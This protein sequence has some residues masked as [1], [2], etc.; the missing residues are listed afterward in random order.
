[1]MSGAPVPGQPRRPGLRHPARIVALVLSGLLA[2]PIVVTMWYALRTPTGIGLG[3]FG[4][5]LTDGSVW[6]AVGHSALWALAALLLVLLGLVIALLAQRVRRVWRSLLLVLVVPLGMSSLVAG[7][8]FRLIFDQAPQRGTVNALLAAVGGGQPAWL[9]SNLVWVVLISAFA[10]SWLGFVVSLFRA[11][12]DAIPV[13]IARVAKVEGASPYRRLRAIVLPMLRPVFA[14]VL[15][16]MVV[17]AIR[18]FDLL[19]MVVPDPAQAGTDVLATRWQHLRTSSSDTGRPAALAV[20]LFALLIMVALGCIRGLRHRSAPYGGEPADEPRDD[21]VATRPWPRRGLWAVGVVIIV[22]WL[23]PVVTLLATAV[24]SPRD[25]GM[26][27]WWRPALDGLSTGALAEVADAGIWGG[28]LDTLVVAVTATTLVLVVA[29]P[30]AYV[31]AWGGLPRWVTRVS[32]PLFAVLAVAPVQMYAEPLE[33]LLGRSGL[34][35]SQLP[36]ALV[37]AAV[38]AP[39]AVLI[40]R[41]AFASAVAPSTGHAGSVDPERGGTMLGWAW[42]H[43]RSTLI[44]VMVLEFV[45]VWNDFAVGFL[46]SGPEASPLALVLRGEARQFATSAAPVAASA[47]VSSV[48]PVLLLLLTWR[49]VV[50]GLSGGALR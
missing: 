16:T 21:V 30:A 26:V 7:A 49:R 3:N 4:A 47:A 48:V 8:I 29:V 5:V 14:V 37:H 44:A 15:L 39:F 43:A 20:V 11:G 2:V 6:A 40:L 35:G 42:Q 50:A 1:E 28:V 45:L 41:W 23:Y 10:W 9:G 32:T 38:G 22:V 34:A 13:D 25:A 24:R 12:I 18:V 27:G 31:L 17:A 19:L 36:L 46:I 33:Q